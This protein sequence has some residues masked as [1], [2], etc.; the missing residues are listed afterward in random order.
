MENEWHLSKYVIFNKPQNANFIMAFN[1]LKGSRVGLDGNEVPLLLNLDKLQEEDPIFQKFK[2]YG[3]IVNYDELEMIQ[4]M[5]QKS[6]SNSVSLTICPTLACN[7]DC[8]Y[9]FENHKSG[10]MTEDIQDK[11]INLAEQMINAVKSKS[12]HITWYGGEPLLGID[13]IEKMSEKLISLTNEKQINYTASIVTN[14]YLLTQ[15]IVNILSKNKVLRYQIT[16]DGL[17]EVHNA[18]RHLVNGGPTFDVIAENLR[19]LHIPGRINI[20]HNVHN[21]NKDEIPLLK[22]LVENIAKQSG[23]NISYYSAIVFNNPATNREDQVEVLNEEDAYH[24]GLLKDFKNNSKINFKNRFC[25]AQN[26]YCLSIDNE[27]RLYKCWEDVDKPERSFGHVNTWNVKNPFF[28][29]ENPNVLSQYL[30]MYSIF[31]DEE[32]RE[33]KLLPIC[34][35]G[36]PSKRIYSHKHCLP[37]KNHLDELAAIMVE[38]SCNK[39]QKNP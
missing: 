3:I 9:C 5:Y 8:P 14:G 22:K 2:K 18:T 27:G 4:A 39:K 29:A 31:S 37:Y 26:L 20:R 13:I 19:S 6:N 35:G 11:V 10:K 34:A 15:D 33:C 1:L 36:C 28:S 16:L 12:L 17:E 38:K 32:C 21:G 24:I 30:S 7:F 25:G 23:N